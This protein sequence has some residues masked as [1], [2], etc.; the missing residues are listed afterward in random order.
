MST[1]RKPQHRKP[2]SATKVRMVALRTAAIGAVAMPGA[3]ALNAQNDQHSTTATT[4]DEQHRTPVAEV[5]HRVVVAPEKDTHVVLVAK[6]TATKPETAT[7]VYKVKEGDTLSAIA[8]RKLG[9]AS[10]YTEIFALNKDREESDGERFTDP[11]LIMPGW[12][13]TLPTAVRTEAAQSDV[14]TAQASLTHHR[15][16]SASQKTSTT[17]HRSS[18]A[19]S[20]QASD[21]TVATSSGGSL[22]E[23]INEAIS[24]LKR[25]GYDVSYKAVYETAM[26]ESGGNPDSVNESD[27]NAASGHPSIGLM[28]TI[29]STFDE[30]A[31]PGYTDIYNPVDNII[32]AARYA[33]AVYG[34]LDEMV[35]AR[36]DGSCWRGY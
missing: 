7:V 11:S 2:G 13:L 14:V 33:A 35:Q 22:K 28:Q 36:C 20:T 29:Q 26:H 32:A 34:S 3:A 25:H 30:Y 8:E 18:Q 27:S 10:D 4:A 5:G 9:D 16:S 12:S 15:T 6:A 19:S 24:V 1:S 21:A 23:W 31:L 17:A